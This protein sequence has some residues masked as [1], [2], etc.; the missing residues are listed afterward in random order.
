MTGLLPV[1][2][3]FPVKVWYLAGDLA[4]AN[5][6]PFSGL[7]PLGFTAG[8]A[9]D[10]D[11]F[12]LFLLAYGSPKL[13]ADRFTPAVDQM[14]SE[15]LSLLDSTG[16]ATAPGTRFTDGKGRNIHLELV[17]RFILV[18]VGEEDA[19]YQMIMESLRNRLTAGIDD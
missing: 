6:V 1:E 18:T 15:G 14:S 13:A 3:L 10:Y 16:P 9:A 2:P 4:L 5:L 19:D 8:A 7:V 11:G 17:Q 12:R